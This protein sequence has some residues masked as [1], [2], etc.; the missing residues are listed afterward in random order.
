MILATQK[1]IDYLQDLADKAE[2][3]R[4]TH[5]SLIPQGL[6]YERWKLGIT[7]DKASLC[8]QFYTEILAN[9]ELQLHPTDDHVWELEL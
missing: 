2:R 5:P 8:I 1:Q 6:F 4:M 7:S 3:I 9:A